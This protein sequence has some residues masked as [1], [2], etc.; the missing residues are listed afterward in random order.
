MKPSTHKEI[1]DKFI[2]GLPKDTVNFVFSGAPIRKS[3]DSEYPFYT[4]RNFYYLTGI[5]E[6][7]AILVMDTRDNSTKLFLR[8]VDETMEKWVGYYLKDDQAKE[9]S[10]ID[11]VRYHSDWEDYL[12]D[13]LEQ[14]VK[15]GIDSDD[16][17]YQSK[18]H[19][20]GLSFATLWDPKQIVD[21]KD[22]FVKARMVKHPEEVEKIKD[23]LSLTHD[24]I[25][26]MVEEIK[27]G[28]NEN[29]VWARFEYYGK[30]NMATP[31]FDTILAGGKQA[32]I[33]HYIDNNKTLEDGD[34]L[35]CDLGLKKD[36]YGADVSITLP[37]NGKFTSRQKEIYEAVLNTFYAVEKA[38]R[39]GITLL[40][41][42]ELAKEKLAQACKDLGII[43]SV[44]EIT[45]YYYHGIGHSLGLDTHDV[46][47]GKDY[48]LEPG[49]VITNEPGL[50]IAEENI[51]IRIES[52]FLVT[53]DGCVD[54]G[55]QIPKKVED[56]EALFTK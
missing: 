46:W 14:D 52:D 26:E 27:P 44:D 1:R 11:D 47:V 43:K 9:I 4:N 2:Q 53:E 33:L 25:V 51:G 23:A 19:G 54:L 34:L 10:L 31:M 24:A 38:I 49:N 50:Y 22:N 35:L 36:G 13:L 17:H 55:P 12:N 41:L 32:T 20:S 21:I 16:D 45:N 6:P 18:P 37:I 42:Q 29:D 15:I 3:A 8:D 30:R 40:D 56:I 28:N 39:P 48:K 5:E 7:E